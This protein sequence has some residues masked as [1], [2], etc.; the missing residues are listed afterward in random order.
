MKNVQEACEATFIYKFDEK[1]PLPAEDQIR[2]QLADDL[3]R[4]K[5]IDDEI[6]ACH[7][8]HVYI[9]QMIGMAATGRMPL[10]EVLMATAVQFV[11]VGMEMAAAEPS[12]PTES[13]PGR[14]EQFQ[15]P[16]D[17]TGV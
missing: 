8:I 4:W 9:A 14:R 3:A 15:R 12:L 10:G 6:R 1:S 5:G 11:A 13:V 2:Q 7:W 17:Y 16:N